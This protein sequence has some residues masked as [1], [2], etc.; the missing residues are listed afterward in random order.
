MFVE[1]E[2]V[3]QDLSKASGENYMSGDQLSLEGVTKT[4]FD[5]DE[6]K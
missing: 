2:N 5:N 3:Q 6:E 1:T 4:D